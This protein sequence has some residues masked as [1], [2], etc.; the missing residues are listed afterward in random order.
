MVRIDNGETMHS[1][2]D[3]HVDFVTL[4]WRNN[5]NPDIHGYSMAYSPDTCRM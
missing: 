4:T 2:D 1:A 3:V 5:P